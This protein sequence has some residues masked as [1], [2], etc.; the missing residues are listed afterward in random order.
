[1]PGPEYC[2]DCRKIRG[3]PYFTKSEAAG[4]FRS[5]L[6]ETDPKNPLASPPYG[7]LGGPPPIRVRVGDAEVLLDDSRL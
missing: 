1:M 5:Y 7:D 2:P 3:N 4:L 6:G